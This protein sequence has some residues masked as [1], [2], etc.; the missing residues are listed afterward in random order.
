MKL[1]FKSA[2]V[3]GGAGFIGS[4]LCESLLRDGHQVLC[5]DNFDPFYDPAIKQGNLALL[6][7]WPEFRFF[8]AQEVKIGTES[9]WLGK[10]G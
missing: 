1:P 2:L 5:L 10:K 8:E 4:H 3:T 6:S 7:A 9:L